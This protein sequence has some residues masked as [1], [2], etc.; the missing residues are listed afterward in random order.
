M[1]VRRMTVYALVSFLLLGGPALLGVTGAASGEID[2]PVDSASLA[3]S[4]FASGCYR[5]QHL[6]EVW[7]KPL[8]P[9]RAG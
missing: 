3:R 8:S 5:A 6:E 2:R 1:M 9:T 4:T 7:G